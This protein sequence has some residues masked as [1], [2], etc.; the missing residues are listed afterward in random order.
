MSEVINLIEQNP[1]SYMYKEA[2]EIL[3][4]KLKN[5]YSF[6]LQVW[7]HEMPK[8]TKYPKILISR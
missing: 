8:E 2:V 6:I 4:K 5:D 3:S 7:N 1:D